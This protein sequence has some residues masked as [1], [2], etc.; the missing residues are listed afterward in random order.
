MKFGEILRHI[1]VKNVLI[2][3]GNFENSEIILICSDSRKACGN[4]VFVCIKGLSSDGHIY[5]QSAYANGCRIFI[6]EHELQLP[7]DA[8][9]IVTEDTR[10]TLA[11]VSQVFYGYPSRE[12]KVIGI[13]GTKGKTTTAQL[14]YHILLSRG[15]KAGYIGTNGVSFD[16]KFFETKNTTPESTELASYMR[17]MI[18]AGV[19][20]VA[21]EVSSQAIYLDRIYGIEFDTCIFT[22]L[23]PDH[24]GEKE[25]PTFEHYRDC[26]ARLFSDYAPK[27]AIYN[28]DDP[29]SEYMMKN[30]PSPK[31]SYSCRGK[32]DF[33]TDG[34]KI[35][36]FRESGKLGIKFDIK[37]GDKTEHVKLPLPGEYNASNAL[38]AVAACVGAGVSPHD[39]AVSLE[40][41]ALKGRFEVVDALP[42]AT[43]VIDYAHNALSLESV[44]KTLRKY[45][46]HR[47][48]CVFGS[49]GGRTQ[50]RRA[51]LGKVAS[52]FADFCIITSD[53][54]DNEAPE[55]IIDEIAD[56]FVK[57]GAD[58]IKI[59]SRREAVL[60]AVHMAQKDDIVLFAGKGHEDYQL[61]C[62]KKEYF[63]ER[64]TIIEGAFGMLLGR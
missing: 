8:T 62:G 58:Y 44:L 5:A 39:A 36:Y 15:I 18:D 28:A 41:V 22:N 37:V 9:V 3:N 24:I 7:N 38:A 2:G 46:P 61:V 48:I 23:S 55:K 13:T 51:E 31:F 14:I 42:Y 16:G 30:C 17:M 4:S 21:L 59:V 49:V 52:E 11:T 33:S 57:G 43:F 10:K 29:A 12:I 45:N 19:R 35:E 6:A 47:L 63:S 56:A 64:E 50:M 25:H 60:T 32:G 26:K 54:P 27:I 34:E 1:K 40:N 20:Y 53:N